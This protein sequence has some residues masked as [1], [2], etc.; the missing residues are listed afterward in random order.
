MGDPLDF[1]ISSSSCSLEFK[2]E[3]IDPEDGLVL[4]VIRGESNVEGT[5]PA[6]VYSMEISSEGLYTVTFVGYEEHNQ[7]KYC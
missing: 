3:S 5:F 1:V 2:V 6:S 4:G 7:D